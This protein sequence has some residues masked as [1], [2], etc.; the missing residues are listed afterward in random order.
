MFEKSSNLSKSYGKE[1]DRNES[2]HKEDRKENSACTTELFEP[3]FKNS[4]TCS[5]GKKIENL[6]EIKFHENPLVIKIFLK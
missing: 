6:E 1:S 2:F 4:E 5:V 3:T